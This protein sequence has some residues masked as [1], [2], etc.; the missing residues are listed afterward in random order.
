[1]AAVA[2]ARNAYGAPRVG[3]ILGTSTSGIFETE[4]AYR[5]YKNNGAWPQCVRYREQHNL[6]GL[7]D[8][9]RKRLAIAGPGHVI[10][11]CLLVQCKGIC[12]CS[13]FPAPKPCVMPW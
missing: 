8:F 2:R 4:L 11:D 5:A 13:P 12:Q 9:V 6:F 10:F 7:T 3:V 1:M